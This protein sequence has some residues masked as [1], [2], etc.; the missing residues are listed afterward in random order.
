METEQMTPEPDS[1]ISIKKDDDEILRITADGDVKW[2]G[3][4]SK[5]ADVF[6]TILG[7]AIDSKAATAGMRQRTYERAC[8]SILSKAKAMNRDELIDFLERSLQNRSQKR[9]LLTL[10]DED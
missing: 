5:A 1:I 6:M 8:R 7:N 4:P 2:S 9:V 3:K 10:Q